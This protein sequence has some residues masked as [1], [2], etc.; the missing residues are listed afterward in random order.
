[1]FFAEQAK[2]LYDANSIPANFFIDR[3]GNIRW[4]KIGFGTG[5]EEQFSLAIEELLAAPE[6][7][8]P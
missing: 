4:K 3:Q 5:L 8:L 1:M 7:P 6:N 2:E